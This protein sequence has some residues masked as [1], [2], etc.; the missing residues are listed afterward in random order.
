[1]DKTDFNLA[2]PIPK[3][4]YDK[5][6]LAHGG[7]GILSNQL[8]QKIFFSQFDNELLNVQH[9]SAMFNING[10]R[11]AFTTDSY[12]VQP[13]FFP[14][15]NI[16]DLAINGTVND[17]AV[18]GAKPLYIS[19]GFIIEEGFEIE[20]LWRIVL[21]MKQA[22]E[23]AGVKIVTGD[24]KVVNKGKGDKIFINTSGIGIIET[25][26][27]ISPLNVKPGDV[28]ILNGK[29]AEHGI[30]ILSAR[31][32]IEFETTVKSDTA[33]LNDLIDRILKTSKKINVMR[34]PTRGGLAS[35]LNEI[36]S[37][38]N[39]GIAIEEDK[40]LISEEVKGACEILGL[41]PLYIANEGKVLVF[42]P[43]AD[44]D[45]VLNAMK[46]H[47]LGKESSIIGNVTAENKSLVTMKTMIGSSRIVD[48]MSGEQLP[49]I[50]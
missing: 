26:I 38:G 11:L 23:K 29:I 41:D 44:A 6:L 46:N 3:N 8:I 17:L 9:D 47:P 45:K 13:I 24:T 49:R 21:S 39:V 37:K 42:V 19:V 43:K 28:I 27:D 34:D 4:D 16:G 50:C 35:A 30:A 2:C 48:M 40:I 1:M 18:S 20:E 22:A 7:G 32:G 31:E 15:G 14:G 25:G 12:V 10:V 5:I 36:A 33:A